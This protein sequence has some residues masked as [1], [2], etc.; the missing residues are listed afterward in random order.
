MKSKVL[1]IKGHPREF[2]GSPGWQRRGFG[3]GH[4]FGFCTCTL[5]TLSSRAPMIYTG[6]FHPCPLSV[7]GNER[8]GTQLWP[9][10]DPSP[11]QASAA[12]RPPWGLGSAVK[13]PL[14]NSIALA[15][16]YVRGPRRKLRRW[17]YFST[18]ASY[19]EGWCAL[20]E[21]NNVNAVGQRATLNTVF[22]KGFRSK[23]KQLWKSALLPAT[24]KFN[25]SSLHS[26]HIY[27]ILIWFR[28]KWNSFPL[29]VLNIKL[30]FPKFW[31]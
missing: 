20:K 1:W 4:C 11:R 17:R 8:V 31:E 16:I 2:G 5:V 26:S 28:T 27:D 25:L 3:V 13:L 21:I 10:G 9:K 24:H 14:E 7:S 29:V 15:T 19:F 30:N 23:P 18:W 6:T 22:F 12:V